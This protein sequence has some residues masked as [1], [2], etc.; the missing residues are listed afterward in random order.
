MYMLSSSNL[1]WEQQYVVRFLE[2]EELR[3]EN[4]GGSMAN[5]FQV[6]ALLGS[7]VQLTSSIVIIKGDIGFYEYV[8]PSYAKTSSEF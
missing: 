1:S 3:S 8:W 4:S 5:S 6:S 2:N 7:T